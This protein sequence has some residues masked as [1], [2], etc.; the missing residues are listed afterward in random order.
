MKVFQIW[1]R[2]TPPPEPY[3]GFMRE[4]KAMASRY[5]LISPTDFMGGEW[6]PFSDVRSRLP[7]YMQK[8]TNG[9][10]M[11]FDAMRAKYLSGHFDH[12]YLDVDVQ[13]LKPIALQVQPQCAGPGILVGNGVPADGLAAWA[14]YARLSPAFCRPASLMFAGIPHGEVPADSYRHFY[15]HGVY[16]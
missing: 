15:A 10:L 4:I 14:N 1:D 11:I 6:V 3:A 16:S 2:V 12:V 13:L 5:T 8:N 9:P 7:A